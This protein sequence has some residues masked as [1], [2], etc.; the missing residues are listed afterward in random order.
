MPIQGAMVQARRPVD[1]VRSA[2]R[3]NPMAYL[4]RPEGT[5]PEDLHLSRRAIGGLM[6]AGYTLAA[7]PLRADPIT[8]DAKGLFTAQVEIPSHGVK[9]PGYLAMPADAR[10][11]PVVLVVS[12]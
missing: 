3:E 6:F 9:L 1:W 4:S 10:K 11:R 7:G 2:M 12:E 5:A 8:T